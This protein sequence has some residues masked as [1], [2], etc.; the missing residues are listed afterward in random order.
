MN[1]ISYPRGTRDFS[2]KE[3]LRRNYIVEVIKNHF[4]KF[5][6][7]PIETP[8]MEYLSTLMNSYG[9]EGEKLIFKILNSGDYL[10]AIPE[11]N[12][13]SMNHKKLM[14]LICEKALRYDLTVPFARYVVQHRNDIQF[15]FKRYQIQAVWRADRPQKGRFREF[16]QCDA[17]SIGSNSLWLDVEYAQLYESVFKSLG[18]PISI[19]INN[20]KI[21][22]GIA[23]IS[24]IPDK[25]TGLAIALD[26]VKKIGANKVKE[27]WMSLG[28]SQTVLNKLE[29]IFHTGRSN[30]E[31]IECLN[32]VLADSEVGK[33]GLDE[34][35]FIIEKTKFL[36]LENILINPSLARGLDYYTGTIYEIIAKEVSI[37]SIGGGGRYDDLT[38]RFGLKGVSGI[39]ISFGLDRIYIALEELKLFPPTTLEE[40]SL[41][42]FIN[43]GEKQAQASMKLI[44]ELRK[45]DIS[46]ELYPDYS[47]LKKQLS[48]ANKREFKYI[49]MI[50]TE[51]LK[52]NYATIKE[53]KS[54][55]QFQV[56]FKDIADFFDSI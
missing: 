22:A 6:F 43:F 51:E 46:C 13:R 41:V 4:H 32:E 12:M 34:L 44:D 31:I 53:L 15:P 54:G 33:K 24:G 48:Y 11:E 30:A 39:G 28:M 27:K 14:P 37:G 2:P 10:Q 47:K 16:W 1:K 8:S 7:S 18:I 3:V 55:Q 50:G 9:E 42:F 17:D 49:A 36:G 40:Q 20:R 38:G 26:K 35:S 29:F 19:E 5:G 23:E 52:Q 21:I 56:L 45:K 25:M